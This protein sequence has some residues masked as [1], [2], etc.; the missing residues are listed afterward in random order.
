ML[1]NCR[2]ICNQPNMQEMISN[3]KSDFWREPSEVDKALMLKQQEIIE[4]CLDGIKNMDK[5]S[6]GEHL[7]DDL[8]GKINQTC[9]S[10]D[11]PAPETSPEI[12]GE[13]LV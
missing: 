5:Y 6:V 3:K 7:S 10:N 2:E 12:N 1:Q 9:E 11:D 13:D 8:L 4:E